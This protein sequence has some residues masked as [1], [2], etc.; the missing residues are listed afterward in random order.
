MALLLAVIALAAALHLGPV[1]HSGLGTVLTYAL[2]AVAY[3]SPVTGFFFIACSQF[4]PFPEGSLHNPAQAGVL[5]WLPIILLRYHRLNLNRVWRLWPV[6]PWLLWFM[7]LTGEGVFMPNSEYVKA[8]VY[9]VIACQLV[10]ESKGRLLKCLFG[11]CLGAL[12]VMTAYWASQLGLPVEI[13]DWGGEREGFV[14]MGGVR[15][16]SV[17]VWP[18]LLVGIS[19]LLGIQIAFASRSSPVQSPKWLTYA[20]LF[21]SVA[22]LPPLVSTMSHGAYAG[23][24]LVVLALF[25][26]GWVAG[27]EGAFGSPR[28]RMLLKWGAGGLAVVVLLFATDAFQLRTKVYSLENYYKSTSAETSVAASRT[29]V[30]HD[31]INTIMKYPLF[32]IRV[33]GDQEE[34]TSEY[35]SL[36]F[37]LSH[38]VFLD[39]GRTI[40]IPGMLLLIFFFFYPAFNMWYSADRIRFLPFLLA[41]FAMFIFWMS[42]SFQFY[43]TF[44]GLWMLMAMA[45][46][47]RAAQARAARR[48][49]RTGTKATPVPGLARVA[50]RPVGRAQGG[51]IERAV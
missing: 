46:I 19:G 13:N 43:K 25:W 35:A 7:V 23:F 16:D 38:N 41:H 49:L 27:R 24:V 6:L 9:S 3:L 26:S 40:G 44:W 29:G 2:P 47:P 34:I 4:V 32:G 45:V 48:R 8:L 42:L 51:P 10:N 1:L 17:M 15:A 21:L 50:P 37:Y 36:G 30:W 31:S 39:Y 12:L 28:F 14:R 18:A 33:T 20:T 11:L 22:S 5:V